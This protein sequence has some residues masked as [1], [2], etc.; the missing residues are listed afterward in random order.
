MPILDHSWNAEM[1]HESR[2]RISANQKTVEFVLTN[3]K[4]VALYFQG[5]KNESSQ[6]MVESSFLRTIRYQGAL[7]S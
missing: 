1:R 6:S 3:Q 5:I 7:E 4:P 2:F